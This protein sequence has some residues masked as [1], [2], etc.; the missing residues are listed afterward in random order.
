MQKAIEKAGILVEA[1][2]YIQSFRDKRLVIKLG[3]AAMT[4]SVELTDTLT[5][6]VFF[7]AVGMKPILVH[8]GGPAVSREMKERGK[9]RSSSTDVG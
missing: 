2:S 4:G 1:L 6:V 7:A 3:G 5:D 8:G 9:R